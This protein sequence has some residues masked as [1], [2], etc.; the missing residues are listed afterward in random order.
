VTKKLPTYF[1]TRMSTR[2]QIVI[3]MAVRNAMGWDIGQTIIVEFNINPSCLLLRKPYPSS[4]QLREI[5]KRKKK[6]D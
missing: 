4:R 6:R 3:P 2:G 1:A 5:V